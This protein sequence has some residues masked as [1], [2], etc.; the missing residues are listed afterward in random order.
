M[1]VGRYEGVNMQAR[2]ACG[3]ASDGLLEAQLLCPKLVNLVAAVTGVRNGLSLD[4][5]SAWFQ[6]ALL[7]QQ[8]CHRHENSRRV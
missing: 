6:T 8:T 3:A 5:S 2:A 1:V 4:G 7:A